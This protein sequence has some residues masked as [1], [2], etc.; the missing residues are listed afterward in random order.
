MKE[1]KMSVK[2]F[3]EKYMDKKSSKWDFDKF[4][5]V[6]NKCMSKVVEFNGFAQAESGYYDSVELE[7][8]IIVKCHKCGNAF[9]IRFDY[10]NEL[11]TDGK[12][13]YKEE[14]WKN[15]CVG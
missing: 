2:E 11:N 8:G 12:K 15:D 14:E 7:G 1:T 9:K 13:R 10:D 6:C 4:S 3:K 5:I